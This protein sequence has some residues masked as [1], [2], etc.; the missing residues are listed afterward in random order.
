MPRRLVRGQRTK[1]SHEPPKGTE[2]AGQWSPPGQGLPS[3]PRKIGRR[4]GRSYG[5]NRRLSRGLAKRLC[6][7]HARRDEPRPSEIV[8]RRTSKPQARA[9]PATEGATG[10]GLALPKSGP[11]QPGCEKEASPD[12]GYSGPP[13]QADV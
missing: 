4:K 5:T 1:A 10:T 9:K 13:L 11:A 3:S 12:G 6:K 7:P 2:Y 8:R